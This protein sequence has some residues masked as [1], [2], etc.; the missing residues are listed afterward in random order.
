[1]RHNKLEQATRQHVS[2]AFPTHDKLD[3][4]IANPPKTPSCQD[5]ETRKE[6]LM[7]GGAGRGNEKREMGGCFCIVGKPETRSR[8][9]AG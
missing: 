7:L 4:R 3:P 5:L 2:S 1:V 6:M 8:K 9:A